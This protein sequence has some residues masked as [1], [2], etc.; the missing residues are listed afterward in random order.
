MT[1]H[2]DRVQSNSVSN[3]KKFYHLFKVCVRTSVGRTA[4]K[5]VLLKLD[6]QHCISGVNSH[7]LIRP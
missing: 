3:K 4:P 1:E 7:D 5:S 2:V 6:L